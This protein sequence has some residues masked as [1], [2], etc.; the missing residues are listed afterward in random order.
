[1]SLIENSHV[2]VCKYCIT[3]SGSSLDG[4]TDLKTSLND[5]LQKKIDIKLKNSLTLAAILDTILNIA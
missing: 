1:M 2:K 3:L 5:V 4:L